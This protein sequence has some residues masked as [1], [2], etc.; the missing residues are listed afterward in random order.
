MF[1]YKPYGSPALGSPSDGPGYT[2]HVS[3]RDTALVYMQARYYDPASGKFLSV[4]P[5]APEAGN[6]FSFNRYAYANNNPYKFVDPDGRFVQLF[7]GGLIGAAVEIAAQK[8]TNPNASINWTSVGVSAA[9]GAATGGVASVARAAAVRGAITFSQAVTR[10]AVANAA[11]S[12]AGSATDSAANGEK[13]SAGKMVVAA[14]IG[15]TLGYGAGRIANAEAITLQKMAAAP[16]TS[17][18]AIGAHI[19]AT[20]QSASVTTATQSA[21]A[22]VAE[23]GANVAGAV[24][25][26][27]VE[28]RIDRNNQL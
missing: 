12:A 3:D 11:I 8:I 20:T 7:L 13:P 27:E 23:N 22:V 10:T 9:V 14:V 19:A 28:G 17:P 26:K 25:Q 24:A 4:D 5:I 16:V 1:D 15:G 21:A 18:Q 2:A 6:S